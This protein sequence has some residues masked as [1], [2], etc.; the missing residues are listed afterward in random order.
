MIIS[1]IGNEKNFRSPWYRAEIVLSYYCV[2]F[3]RLLSY[4]CG[5]YHEVVGLY[6]YHDT[7]ASGR[8]DGASLI[9]ARPK[10]YVET[11]GDESWN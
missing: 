6:P 11:Q 1:S 9:L 3:A 2:F 5:K 10:D 4:L 8:I 7:L